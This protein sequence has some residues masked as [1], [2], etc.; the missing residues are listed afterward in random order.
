MVVNLFFFFSEKNAQ[1]S[2]KCH[3]EFV[4]Y[5][6]VGLAVCSSSMSALYCFIPAFGCHNPLDIVYYASTHRGINQRC[7]S[8][9]V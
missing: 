6:H 8:S 3:T 9:T 5:M 4:N 1:N 2:Q 7:D